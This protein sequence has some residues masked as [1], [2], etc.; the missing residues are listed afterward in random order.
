M[1]PEDDSDNVDDNNDGYRHERTRVLHD[2]DGDNVDDSNDGYRHERTRVF[3][4][5]D[6]DNVDDNNDGYRH[7]RT[8]VLPYRDGLHELRPADGSGGHADHSCGSVRIPV[9]WILRQPRR[10]CPRLRRHTLRD[11]QHFCYRSWHCGALC[12]G[13]SDHTRKGC[14]CVLVA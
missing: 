5:D 7:D 3:P 8:R 11:H 13:C 9:L 10:H 12:G 14:R 1:F 6:G 4:E 2:D